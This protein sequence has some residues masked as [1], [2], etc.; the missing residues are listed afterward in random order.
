MIEKSIP[1]SKY[2]SLIKGAIYTFE[3][4]SFNTKGGVRT[5]LQKG[6]LLYTSTKWKENKDDKGKV[7]SR[8]LVQDKAGFEPVA[9]E[10]CWTTWENTGEKLRV[11]STHICCGLFRILP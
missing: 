10:D 6:K 5:R 3:S 2:G 1:V 7:T 8:E 9:E 11:Y 4:Y